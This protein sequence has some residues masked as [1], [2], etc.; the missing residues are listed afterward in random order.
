MTPPALGPVSFA[1]TTGN[2][3]YLDA[4]VKVAGSFGDAGYDIRLA[5]VAEWET[6]VD[7]TMPSV[8][9]V[10]AMELQ[11]ALAGLEESVTDHFKD[12]LSLQDSTG[13]P[14]TNDEG[15][16]TVVG[17]TNGATA[18]VYKHQAATAAS[19]KKNGDSIIASA[20]VAFGQGTAATVAWADKD[21]TDQN[22]QYVALDHSY[23]DG[24]V[25]IYYKR[26]EDETTDVDSSN[27]GVGVGHDI[28]GGA[29]VYAG[30]RNMEEDGKEDVDL[31]VAGMRVTFN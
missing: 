31:I 17:G 14:I 9:P 18:L 11:T 15:L 29:Q 27:W 1:I 26:G 19:R 30:F 13:V 12:G 23:G 25:G 3:D 6:D 24:S 2:D 16:T 28:G 20:S 7:A 5:H 10:R 8:T 21:T 4:M 22:Y